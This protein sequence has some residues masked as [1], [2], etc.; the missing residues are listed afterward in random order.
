VVSF[1]YDFGVVSICLNFSR[2]LLA[3]PKNMNENFL[4][5]QISFDQMSSIRSKL[6]SNKNEDVVTE[7]KKSVHEEIADAEGGEYENE[8]VRNPDVVRECDKKD[9]FFPLC[10]DILIFV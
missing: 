3:D 6:E 5:L 2:I 7:R 8:P 10:D 4:S 9:R 1:L